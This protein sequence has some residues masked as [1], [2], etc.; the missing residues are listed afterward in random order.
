MTGKAQTANKDTCCLAAANMY[1]STLDVLW[2]DQVKHQQV[3]RT[4][5]AL[6]LNHLGLLCYLETPQQGI[7]G[8]TAHL[9]SPPSSQAT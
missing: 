6:T 7:A 2:K 5:T 3:C 1:R 8:T 4:G 9:Q